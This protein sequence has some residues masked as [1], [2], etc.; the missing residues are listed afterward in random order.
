[1][2]KF[3]PCA[4]QVCVRNS[5][6][7]CLSCLLPL[8]CLCCPVTNDVHG[9]ILV[10]LLIYLTYTASGNILVILLIYPAS[11]KNQFEKMKDNE[12]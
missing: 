4:K 2:A 12:G 6:I 1:M 5:V 3:K 8:K 10:I 9:H 11:S 7:A